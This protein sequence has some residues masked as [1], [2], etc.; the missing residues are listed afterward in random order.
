MATSYLIQHFQ[1]F[2]S[3]HGELRGV[4]LLQEGR[5]GRVA[6][7]NVRLLPDVDGQDGEGE[8]RWVGHGPKGGGRGRGAFRNP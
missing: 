3:S 5:G 2:F 7:R 6:R 1:D 4:G 8:D